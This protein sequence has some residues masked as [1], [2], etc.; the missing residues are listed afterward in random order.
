MNLDAALGDEPSSGINALTLPT[1][2]FITLGFIDETIVNGQGNDIFV[3]EDG[4]AGDRANVFISS[5]FTD[6]T[7]L[8]VAQDNVTT[9][10][11]L[12]SINYTQPVR[13]IKV[14][15]LNLAGAVPGFDL[16]NVQALNRGSA[17]GTI[18]FESANFSVNE[19]GSAVNEVKV[20]RTDGSFGQ[21]SATINLTNGTATATSD[22]NNEAITVSFANGETGKVV[23]IPIVNDN[24]FESD[25]TINLTLTNPSNGATIGTQNTATFT[26]IN[27]DAPGSGV[28]AFSSPEFS[29]RE[30]GT[31]IAAVTVVRNGGKDGAVSATINFKDGTAK[32]PSDYN[33]TGITVNFADGE[34]SKTVNIP[35]LNNTTAEPNETL[36]LLLTN[37]TGG[38]SVG[39]QN[40]AKL[41]IIDD[42]GLSISGFPQGA[43]GSNKGQTT[44][45]VAGQKFLPT[46]EISLVSSTGTA[47]TASKVY[48]VNDTEAW[49]TFNLQ[50]LTT[51]RY[52]VKVANG[53]NS[54][55]S[56]DSFTVTD[57]SLGNIQVKLSYP[58]NGVVTVKYT[59]VGQTDVVA[60]LLRIVPTNAQV[61]YP[62]EN[63]VSATL[64]QL[65]NLSLGTSDDGPAGILAP[66]ENGEFSFAYTPNGN[67]LISFAVEQVQ[68]NEVINWASI[69]AESR[70]DYSFINDAGWDAI[71]S[72]LTAAVGTTAG[73]FQA[74][75]TEN[76]NYLSQLGQE[77]SDLTRLF[78]FE[79]K[80]AVNTLT[81]VSLIST[82]DVVDAAPGLSLTFNRTFY[83]SL[84]ERYNLGGLGRGWAGQWDLRATTDSKGD[85]IVRSVGDLQRV[86]EKQTDGVTYLEDGGA[87]LTITNGQYRLKEASGLVSLFGTDGKLSYVED[88]NAN[89]IT[90]EYANNNLTKLVHTN[91]DSLTL[92]Y[93]A[94]GRISQ[95]T[96]STAQVTSYS[97]DAAGENLL[98][99]TS[100][101]GTIS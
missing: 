100:P 44:I 91:G 35:I 70:A 18:A 71:W 73:Q 16:V 52:D 47:T 4:A 40:T 53:Q 42:D 56:N 76:A 69:K 84:A 98:S 80:Q 2:S 46:D 37:P 38:A 28:L 66:G 94:Q 64:R 60:P 14:V 27:D 19:N 63:T 62:E 3:R 5:N 15:G 79:W 8:G 33:N 65:L 90:L 43:S 97:Y 92:A 57:G 36:Q 29:I 17:I 83:Q 61:T 82:T 49:A 54:F 75:M 24:R 78:A 95:I 93:N 26:I 1:G 21:V 11:D 45:V 87:T 86:F 34:I 77:T 74:V 10:F 7:F 23:T 50:G 58:A 12:S 41:T 31:P 88:T 68:P 81:N 13:A 85:V 32:A 25:E 39:T 55:V 59:N 6:F 9:A 48:W 51:G 101:D 89:R 67:G 72:N 20:I 96:D 22:Y 99:V 30:D